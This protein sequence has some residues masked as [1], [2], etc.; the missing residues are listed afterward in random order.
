MKIDLAKVA[1]LGCSGL[2]GG[3]EGEGGLG[4]GGGGVSA[5]YYLFHGSMCS[6][7]AKVL[8]RK[9]AITQLKVSQSC[10]TFHVLTRL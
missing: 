3:V 8:Q 1:V 9:S 2:G 6:K 4:G 10:Y 5:N 7:K